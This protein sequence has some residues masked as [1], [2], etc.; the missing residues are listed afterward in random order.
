M[1]T[2]L[3]AL[4]IFFALPAYGQEFLA[5]G[6]HTDG[7]FIHN[8]VIFKWERTEFQTPGEVRCAVRITNLRYKCPISMGQLGNGDD[9]QTVLVGNL[10]KKYPL[11][12]VFMEHY[13]E[14]APRATRR[15]YRFSNEEDPIV[16]FVFK[17]PDREAQ[18][19]LLWLALESLMW[20]QHAA[21]IALEA[22]R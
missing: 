4:L 22:P 8:N 21:R 12:A 17:C 13:D 10:G 6:R 3:A 14:D 7:R 9:Q 18:S 11:I 16:I 19:K 5:E 15:S 20:S 1:R 2:L